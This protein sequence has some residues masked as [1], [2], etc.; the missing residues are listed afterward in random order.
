MWQASLHAYLADGTWV[1]VWMLLRGAAGVTSPADQA[2]HQHKQ[3]ACGNK[4][5]HTSHTGGVNLLLWLAKH[6][7]DLISTM[8][9]VHMISQLSSDPWDLVCKAATSQLWL[10][11]AIHNMAFSSPAGAPATQPGAAQF[12]AD[13]IMVCLVISSLPSNSTTGGEHQSRCNLLP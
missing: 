3:S 4:S 9:T 7:R 6:A 8:L 10:P 11:I 12:A 1:V 2:L 5:A 13:S